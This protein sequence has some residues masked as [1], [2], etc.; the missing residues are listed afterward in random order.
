MTSDGWRPVLLLCLLGTAIAY[1]RKKVHLLRLEPISQLAR[2]L[3][4]RNVRAL[5]A[6]VLLLDLALTGF[7]NYKSARG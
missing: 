2:I 1:L 4:T 7:L 6:E 5:L 3:K